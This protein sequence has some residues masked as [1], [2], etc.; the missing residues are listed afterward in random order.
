MAAR[1]QQGGQEKPASGAGA[2]RG[3]E[4]AHL[5]FRLWGEAAL[6]PQGLLARWCVPADD[7]LRPPVLLPVLYGDLARLHGRKPHCCGLGW[8]GGGGNL[9]HVSDRRQRVSPA[10][11]GL[12]KGHQ[13]MFRAGP[14]PPPTARLVVPGAPQGPAPAPGCSGHKRV[15]S[16]AAAPAKQRA[17]DAGMGQ[18]PLGAAKCLWLQ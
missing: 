15:G 5:G 9:F 7:P 16:V 1:W 6:L 14:P 8:A 12:L 10:Q 4:W 17:K 13:R 11:G 3:R 18:L 2:G